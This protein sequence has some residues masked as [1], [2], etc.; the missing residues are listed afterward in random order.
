VSPPTP[1]YLPATGHIDNESV[2]ENFEFIESNWPSGAG[3][4]GP[5]GPQGPVG[6]SGPQGAPG[7]G[8][9]QSYIAQIGDGA[10]QTF[11]L[12]HNLGI[13]GVGVFVYRATAPF[14]EIIADVQRTDANHVTIVTQSVPTS[15]QYTVLVAGPGQ[16]GGQTTFTYTQASPAATWTITHNL[17]RW[18]SVTVVDS[19]NTVIEPDIN[20]ID[21]NT[22]QVIF[23]SATSGK[24]YLN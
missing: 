5:Q 13:Q 19:G 20:Y 8:G 14:D 15:N 11:V 9:G 7:P 10:S 24:A 1:V 16:A 6:P 23:S 22:L 2:K 18:P 21:A 4:P 17:N 3:P 12:A